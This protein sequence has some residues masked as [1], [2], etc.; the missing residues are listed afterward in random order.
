MHFGTQQPYKAIMKEISLT[1]SE[2]KMGMW[3]RHCQSEQTVKIGW[4]I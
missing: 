4:L 2:D 1:F 3:E